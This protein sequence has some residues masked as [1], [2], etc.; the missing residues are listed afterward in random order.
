MNFAMT[1]ATHGELQQRFDRLWEV[2]AGL[3]GRLAATPP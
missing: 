3:R 2:I 1:S